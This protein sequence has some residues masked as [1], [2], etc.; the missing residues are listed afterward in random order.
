MSPGDQRVELEVVA[1][2]GHPHQIGGARRTV[3]NDQRLVVEHAERVHEALEVLARVARR[4]LDPLHER[5]QLAPVGGDPLPYGPAVEQC[6]RR[7]T[8]LG[9]R[10]PAERGL[11]ADTVDDLVTQLVLARIGQLAAAGG[12]PPV[13]ESE[14]GGEGLPYR[15]EETG[16]A[17]QGV[18]AALDTGTDEHRGHRP[19]PRRDLLQQRR[20]PG[21]SL[22]EFVLVRLL[23]RP[24]EQRE[25]PVEPLAVLIAHGGLER[26]EGV[27]ECV[28]C[29][30]HPETLF[31]AHDPRRA[32]GRRRDRVRRSMTSHSSG[33]R[34][35]PHGPSRPPMLTAWSRAR[36]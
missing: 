2:A 25:G 11:E 30:C 21:R 4:G 8:P 9:E 27:R 29:R 18:G 22:L 36:S 32:S 10:P 23:E 16:R 15:R 20:Q 5:P 14:G 19:G 33:S 26:T 3:Q 31:D 28:W 6:E 35:Y 17:R 24:V 7:H 34:C 13:G 1:D 12:R